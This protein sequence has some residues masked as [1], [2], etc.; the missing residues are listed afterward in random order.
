MSLPKLCIQRPVLAIVI[1]V[2]LLIVG[3]MGFD[4]LTVRELP[5]TEQFTLQ[6]STYY[7]GA[8]AE[9]IENQIT[10]PIENRIAGVEGIDVISSYSSQG[11]SSITITFKPDYD[12]KE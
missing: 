3:Y 10:V 11:S 7:R 8:S 5:K 6:I 4:R 1:N 12:I 2:L 9:L